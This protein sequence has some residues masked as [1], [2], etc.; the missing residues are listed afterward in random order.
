MMA[1]N[2]CTIYVSFVAVIE[3]CLFTLDI[4]NTLNYTLYYTYFGDIKKLYFVAIMS[5]LHRGYNT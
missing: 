2:N 4:I 3:T 1:L 5:Y